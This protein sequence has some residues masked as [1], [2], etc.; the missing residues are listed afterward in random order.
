MERVDCKDF[1]DNYEAWLDKL[2]E[3][4]NKILDKEMELTLLEWHF[5]MPFWN[6][7]NIWY[8]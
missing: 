1:L 2:Q 3:N 4:Y 8:N 7:N 6:W 5:D